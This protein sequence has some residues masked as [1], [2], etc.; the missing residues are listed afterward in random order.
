MKKV[1]ITM[2]EIWAATRPSIQKSKKNYS[3]KQKHKNKENN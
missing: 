1:E 3:R 2:N